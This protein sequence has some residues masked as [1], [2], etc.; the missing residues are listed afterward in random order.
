[1]RP[2][3]KMVVMAGGLL[4][5]LF[6]LDRARLVGAEEETKFAHSRRGGILVSA[7]GHRFEV[8]FYP[9]G[10]RVV[11][12]DD[13]GNPVDTSRLTA[14]ATFY[15]PTPRKSL[16]SR[17]HSIPIRSTQAMHHRPWS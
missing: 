6:G 8:F 11:P 15:H 4:T 9:N 14:S 7:E 17:G 12:L 16:G 10:V 3:L 13:A 5:C 2:I 1:M